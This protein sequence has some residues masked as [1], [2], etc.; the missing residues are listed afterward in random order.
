MLMNIQPMEFFDEVVNPDL[1]EVSAL[2]RANWAPP[3]WLYERDLLAMHI[4]RPTADP[5]MAVG[6]RA[7]SGELASYLA[8]VPMRLRVE[9]RI[10]KAVFASFFTV[11]G[12]FRRHRLSDRQ[13]GLMVDRAR[14]HGYEVYT[15][16]TVA[17]TPANQTVAR[18]F[19]AR[20]LPVRAAHNFRYLA[21]AGAIVSSRLAASDTGHVRTYAP[22][23]EGTAFALL[24]AAAARAP[25]AHVVERED[26]D[27]YLRSRPRIKTYVYEDEGR[28]LGLM[29]VSLLP[30]LSGRVGLNAYVEA[31]A[32]GRLDP[33]A[34]TAF[35]DTVLRSVLDEGAEA[36]MVPDT[37]CGDLETFRRLGF[38]AAPRKLR[39]LLAP[40]RTDVT[41]LP[42]A[43]DGFCLD[44]F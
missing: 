19:G 41:D 16:V 13:Q 26:V 25:L 27:F 39:L 34:R 38:R 7:K 2:M 12:N 28:V 5:T 24:S 35:V 23:D 29:S 6:L 40:L 18:A 22:S 42:E 17:G 4:M 3:C 11:S 37:G 10:Y 30:V 43:V 8:F 9:G 21:G 44:V 36:I 15:A 33:A 14:D 31:L 32:L 20:G 1:D